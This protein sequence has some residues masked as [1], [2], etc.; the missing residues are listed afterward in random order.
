[1][2]RISFRLLMNSLQDMEVMRRSVVLPVR[3]RITNSAERAWEITV[4]MAAPCT[5]IP[6]TKMNNGSSRILHSAP[7]VTVTMPTR[8][9]PCALMNG[10][11]PVA[12]MENRLPR[13]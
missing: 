13:R 6:N 4:A 9:N 7:I 5:P 3:K 12:I 10:F 2:F 1:M 8:G 11:I